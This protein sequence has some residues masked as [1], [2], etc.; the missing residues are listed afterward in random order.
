MPNPEYDYEQDY[1]Y[2]HPPTGKREMRP[3]PATSPFSD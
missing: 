2:E 1:D 3:E